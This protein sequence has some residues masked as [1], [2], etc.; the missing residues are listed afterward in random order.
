[1]TENT[2]EPEEREYKTGNPD[3]EPR[4]SGDQ[5]NDIR[6]SEEEQL[7]REQSRG[8]MPQE[9]DVPRNYADIDKAMAG[10]DVPDAELNSD[11]SD[12]PPYHGQEH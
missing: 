3:D 5:A 10:M 7:I 11:A 2:S 8:N 1:M 6:F 4:D 9:D 12:S